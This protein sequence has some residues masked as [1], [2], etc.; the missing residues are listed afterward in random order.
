MAAPEPFVPRDVTRVTGCVQCLTVTEFVKHDLVEV[1]RS[2]ARKQVG[3]DGEERF[4]ETATGTMTIVRYCDWQLCNDSR[5]VTWFRS[6]AIV[7]SVVLV[8]SHLYVT[9]A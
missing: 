6:G 5:R 7:C 4:G 1:T 2:C 8:A 9:G 3:S